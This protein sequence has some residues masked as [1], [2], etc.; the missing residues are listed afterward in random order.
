MG[1]LEIREFQQAIVNYTNTSPLPIEIKRLVIS[2]IL[3]QLNTEAN[4]AVQSE[5]AERI[6]AEREQKKE[7]EDNGTEQAVQPD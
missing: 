6:N 5:L 4:A 3:A 2:D 1:N 7:V